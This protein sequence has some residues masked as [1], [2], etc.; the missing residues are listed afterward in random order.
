MGSQ[1]ET[2]LSDLSAGVYPCEG[3]SC[4]KSKAMPQ[5][6]M[7]VDGVVASYGIIGMVYI[8]I[9]MAACAILSRLIIVL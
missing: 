8:S 4:R 3:T 5:T 7:A 9:I 6:K 2:P 1:S